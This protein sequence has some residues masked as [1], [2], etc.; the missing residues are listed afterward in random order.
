LV[1]QFHQ[2]TASTPLGRRIS[3]RDPHTG[4]SERL[5]WPPSSHQRSP[6]VPDAKPSE[7]CDEQLLE[8]VA[9]ATHAQLS[10]RTTFRLN[11]STFPAVDHVQSFTSRPPRPILFT[12]L[13]F[14][15]S[16]LHP[17]SRRSGSSQ[18][19]VL[20]LGRTGSAFATRWV[21]TLRSSRHASLQVAANRIS[22]PSHNSRAFPI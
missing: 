21:V 7:K 15:A 19:V 1:S 5:I 2:R 18:A 16:Q 17:R 8:Q 14:A 20:R 10:A 13:P 12:S 6:T 11:P 3:K 22:A 4:E 9:I